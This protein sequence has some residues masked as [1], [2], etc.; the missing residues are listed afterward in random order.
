MLSN[1]VY[2]KPF[3]GAP[4]EVTGAT[5]GWEGAHRG[6]NVDGGNKCHRIN[7]KQRDISAQTDIVVVYW[8]LQR[9]LLG[10]SFFFYKKLGKASAAQ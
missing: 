9:I 3:R 6:E 7:C 5:L 4:R 8:L 10:F 1:P 2:S